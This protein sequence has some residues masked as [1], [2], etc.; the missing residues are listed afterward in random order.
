MTPSTLGPHAHPVSLQAPAPGPLPLIHSLAVLVALSLT[1]C[2]A[3]LPKRLAS[4]ID[5]PQNSAASPPSSGLKPQPTIGPQVKPRAQPANAFRTQPSNMRAAG[6]LRQLF[7]K[8]TVTGQELIVELRAIRTAAQSQQ[9]QRTFTTLMG[10]VDR[11]V[12]SPRASNNTDWKGLLS[13]VSVAVLAE[14]RTSVSNAALDNFMSTVVGDQAALAKETIELPSADGLDR[15]QQ[16]RIANMAAMVIGARIA[17]RLSAD[18]DKTFSSLETEYSGLME[19]REKIAGV[20]ADVV[21]KR[22]KAIAARDEAQARQIN[23]DLSR[24]LTPA[25]IEF[26]DK[27][28]TSMSLKEFSNDFAMQN[29][30]VQFLQR[31]DPSAYKEY[32]AQADG[33]V[34]HTKAYVQTV[35]GIA[36]FGGL[37]AGFIKEATDMTKNKN[38]NEILTALPLGIE[39]VKAAAPLIPTAAKAAY[40]GI[41]VEPSE[42]ITGMIFG[43]KRFRVSSSDTENDL[44]SASDVFDAIRNAGEEVRLQEALFRSGSTG[45]LYKLYT[46][47]AEATGRMLDS[48]IPGELRDKFGHDFM[49]LDENTRFEFFN[50]LTR[51]GFPR[52]SQLVSTF[53]AQDQRQ[54]ATIPVVGEAQRQVAMAY[55]KWNE[56]QLTRLIIANHTGPA[57]Y[58]QLQVGT[59][60]I[61]LIPSMTAVYEYESYQDRCRSTA[62][63][64]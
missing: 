4:A 21:D 17:N 40:S 56:S 25:D 31:R 1:G 53:L 10:A 55:G 13:D 2:D 47:D 44:R 52:H 49:R 59:V 16:Q 43:S 15:A 6:N 39:F 57:T 27:F 3:T 22:K 34:G 20:L 18:A 63:R 62:T 30:A 46:C 29:I 12:S 45:F 11:S 51:P 64:S 8:R 32:R 61:R 50:A 33:M 58:A 19:R 37:L 36:A 38:N 41:A 24:W 48:T 28:G 14:M 60:R 26:I 42:G 54:R 23:A 7:A 9:T 5:T 35:G